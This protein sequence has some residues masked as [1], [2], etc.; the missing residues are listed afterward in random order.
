MNSHHNK[1][2]QVDM[3]RKSRNRAKQTFQ[4]TAAANASTNANDTDAL[5]QRSLHGTIYAAKWQHAHHLHQE[6]QEFCAKMLTSFKCCAYCAK[7]ALGGTAHMPTMHFQQYKKIMVPQN[8]DVP[9]AA[10]CNPFL[11]EHMVV[12]DHNNV[13]THWWSCIPCTKATSRFRKLQYHVAFNPEY[14]ATLLSLPQEHILSLGV[15]T[16][17]MKL[18]HRMQGFYHL[19]VA[20]EV[21]PLLTGPLII[22]QSKMVSPLPSMFTEQMASTLS[23]LKTHNPL[24][25]QFVTAYEKMEP[26]GCI[27]IVPLQTISRIQQVQSKDPRE[28]HVNVIDMEATT[29]INADVLMP[30]EHTPINFSALMEGDMLTSLPTEHTKNQKYHAGSMTLRS[31]MMTQ[32]ILTDQSGKGT[33]GKAHI[34][35]ESALFP[36]LFPQNRGWADGRFMGMVDYMRMRSCQLF[37]PFTL[38]KPYTMVMFQM[39]M[40]CMLVNNVQEAVLEKSLQHFQKNNPKA[41]QAQ[42]MKHLMKRTV[43]PCLI[44]SSAYHR[45]ALHDLL[46]IVHKHKMPQ[47]FLTLTCD[48]VSDS[49]WPEFDTL[50]KFLENYG[51]TYTWQ[52]APVECARLFHD[53]VTAFMNAYILRKENP[54]LGKV[55]HYLIRYESQHRG[56]LHAHILL[57]LDEDDVARVEQEITASIPIH[58]DVDPTDPNKYIYIEPDPNTMEY[59]LMN[60]VMAK[61]QHT[62]RSTKYGCREDNKPCQRRFPFPPNR[63]GTHVNKETGRYEYFRFDELDEWVVPYHPL[64]LLLWKAHCNLLRINDTQWSQYILKYAT[65]IEPQVNITYD[66]NIA[67]AMGLHGFSE[68]ELQL[69]TSSILTKP[70]APCEAAAILS[71]IPIIQCDV[72]VKYIDTHPLPK[73]EVTIRTNQ[74]Y[75]TGITI[76]PLVQY[77]ARPL[78]L[79]NIKFLEYFENFEVRSP[80]QK[81]YRVTQH[82]LTK[83]I[84]NTKFSNCKSRE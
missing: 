81:K 68:H 22:W 35:I 49:R 23:Y 45:K 9:P 47:F 15:I 50:E 33:Y 4:N 18:V 40:S 62:C 19:E 29:E 6:W 13:T 27:P 5:L 7:V 80:A 3:Q 1:R 58:R 41:T 79:Q 63:S 44:G 36:T 43:P 70:V 16:T 24:V 84:C 10:Y 14:V 52:D 28:T 37:S 76:S 54:I 2:Q 72:N 26:T 46:A 11:Y 65:K 77:L 53:R 48:E 78:C 51:K 71:G 75:M 42:A 64:V 82:S 25:Q 57:W 73:R 74:T 21:L 60:L 61:Q 69:I 83:T 66:A 17:P 8:T 34:T 31:T 12:L 67:K 20:D 56:S 38:V 39:Y 59:E 55:K 32:R 30:D